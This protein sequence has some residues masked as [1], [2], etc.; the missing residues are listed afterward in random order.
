MEFPTTEGAKEYSR[1]PLQFEPTS[2]SKCVYAPVFP[3][4]LCSE[5]SGEAR[6]IWSLQRSQ[7]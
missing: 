4:V 2:I 6:I 1:R 3:G 7:H 5:D